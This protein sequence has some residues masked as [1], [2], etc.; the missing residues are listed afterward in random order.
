[1]DLESHSYS[2]LNAILDPYIKPLTEAFQ[3]EAEKYCQKISVQ[4]KCR[5]QQLSLQQKKD[6]IYF[7]MSDLDS[8]TKDNFY[9]IKFFMIT[10]NDIFRE[11]SQKYHRLNSKENYVAGNIF[12][13]VKQG[14]SEK[15]RLSINGARVSINDLRVTENLDN[16][17][18]K[19]EQNYRYWKANLDQHLF[20]EAQRIIEEVRDKLSNSIL[21]K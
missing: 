5:F 8:Q 7:W 18:A 1:M 12:G 11:I 17:Q 10:V 19:G 16:L 15:T 3:Q 9:K 14:F 4:E 6:D 21:D 2:Y 13:S 20:S